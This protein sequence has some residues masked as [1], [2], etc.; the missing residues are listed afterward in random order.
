M[1]QNFAPRGLLIPLLIT[2]LCGALAACAGGPPKPAKARMT[3]AAQADANPD[4]SGRPSPI[5]V[6]VFQLKSDGAF[7]GADFF[8]LFDDE[9]KALGPDIVSREE[10]EL[11]PGERRT[12]DFAVSGDAHFIGAIAAFRDIRNSTWRVLQAAPKK[13]IKN[14]VKKDALAVSVE[15]SR[16]TLTI[17]D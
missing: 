2:L 4:A 17:A 15:K 13:G 6:R 11:S 5:V 12:M 1:K 8:A 7:A 3:V 14:L 16:V 10:F 9:K